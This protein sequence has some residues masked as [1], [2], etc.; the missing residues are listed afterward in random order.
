[1]SQGTSGNACTTLRSL[2]ALLASLH[3]RTQKRTSQYFVAD[4]STELYKLSKRMLMGR[5]AW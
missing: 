1:M 3:K 4:A 2:A 5:G